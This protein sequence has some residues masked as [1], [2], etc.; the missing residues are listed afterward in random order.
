MGDQDEEEVEKLTA[1][2]SSSTSRRVIAL[3]S[4]RERLKNQSEGL[5]T[6]RTR[7]TTKP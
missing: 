6:P 3:K 5:C 4:V 7:A 2:R 1:L